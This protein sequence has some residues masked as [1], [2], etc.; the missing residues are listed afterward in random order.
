M[1]RILASAELENDVISYH[2]QNGLN[3]FADYCCK[4]WNFYINECKLFEISN[5]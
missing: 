3:E 2:R 5:D 1:K 4:I